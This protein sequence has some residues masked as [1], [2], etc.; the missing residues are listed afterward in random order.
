MMTEEELSIMLEEEMREQYE[1]YLTWSV[2][3]SEES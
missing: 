1:K 3:S 2:R